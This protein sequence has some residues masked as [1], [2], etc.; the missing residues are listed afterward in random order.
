MDISVSVL[1]R[2]LFLHENG[3]SELILKFYLQINQNR[4][5]ISSSESS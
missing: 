5:G 3:L 2:F 1:L 4:G